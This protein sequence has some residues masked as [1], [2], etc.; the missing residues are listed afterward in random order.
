M[1]ATEKGLWFTTSCR[2]GLVYEAVGAAQGVDD[3]DQDRRMI[4]D[5]S[6]QA[7]YSRFPASGTVRDRAGRNNPCGDPT[8]PAEDENVVGPACRVTN[9]DEEDLDTIRW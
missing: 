9:H 1:R 7:M 4:T 2:T 6:M 3:R 5:A 8:V